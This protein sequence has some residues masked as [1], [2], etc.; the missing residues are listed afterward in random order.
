[1]T[2][3]A[4]APGAQVDDGSLI[5]AVAGRPVFV[6]RGRIP[7]YS[8]MSY[9]STGIEVTELQAG[10]EAAGFS[11]GSDTAGTYG[12]GTAA[13]V[14][15]L[16][17]RVGYAPVT[18]PGP[19]GGSGAKHK[20][21]PKQY[22]TV[23]LGEVMF[24]PSLPVTVVS[25]AHLGQTIASGKPLAKL[26]SGRLSFQATT[27]VNTASLLKIGATGRAT[28]DLSNGSFAIRLSAKRPGSAP[29]G[30]PG[31]KLTFTPV[32][33]AAAAPLRRA[34]HGVA[35]PHRS[36]GRAAVGGAGVGGDHQRVRRVVGHGAA[37]LTAGVR[38][39][40]GGARVR[41]SRGRAADRRWAEGRRPGRDRARWLGMSA[42]PARGEQEL[43]TLTD[44]GRTYP[45]SPPVHALRDAT[46]SVL[47]GEVLGIIG[48]SGSGKSTLLNVLG[49]LDLPTSGDYRVEGQRVGSLS[50]R[51]QTALRARFFGFVF[52]QS[53]LLPSLSAQENVELGLRPRRL[54]PGE[55]RER[56]IE[57]LEAVGL[58][59]RRRF[60]PGKMSGGECQRVAIARALAQRPRVLLCDEPTG[61]LDERTSSEV[62][63][64]L[65]D[66][67]A[68]DV[69]VVMVTH[70]MGIARTLPRL[71]SVRD[72]VV[73]EGAGEF[74]DAETLP[75]GEQP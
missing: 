45:G 67:Q 58:S 63:Q 69:A 25:V 17:Q 30:G 53:F 46:F 43:L 47:A 22:A 12:A 51:E 23:P 21:R 62:L 64:M 10:L 61:N 41:G 14:A 33:P 55:R 59:H 24:T 56:A 31:S 19:A 20:A 52:Q 2:A 6:L 40:S 48:R 75:G 1:M 38:A 35:R 65:I 16:Y 50:D 27:D 26:G 42:A 54:A 49:L 60:L 71:L 36:G 72:G 4:T 68:P 7:A 18:A 34:E 37:R 9:G 11:V 39:R 3:V 15:E 29:G 57:A 13:A 28:S 73:S 66:N 70:D 32:N 74:L 8:T 5:A 44:V